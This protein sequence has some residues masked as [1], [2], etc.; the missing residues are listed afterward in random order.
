MNKKQIL[1]IGLI[2]GLIAIYVAFNFYQKIYGESV[3][4]Q[5]FI[6]IK[7]GDSLNELS[8]YLKP[9]IKDIEDFKWVAKQKSYTKIRAGKFEIKKGI[10]NNDLINHLR[11]GKQTPV[12]VVFNNQDTI[13]KLAGRIA[14][15]IEAD[16]LEILT[17]ITDKKFLSKI[18][19]SREEILGRFIPNTYEFFWNTS[20]VDFRGR[21]LKEYY[22]FWNENRLAKAKKLNMTPIEVMNLASI[23]QK[24]TNKVVERPIVAGLYLNRLKSKMPLQADPT[25][26]YILKQQKGQD[27]IVKRV[28][29]KD[30]KIKSP[31]NTYQNRGLP[32]AL[33]SM[34]DI[35]SIDA[36][37]N[38]KKHNFYYMCA[39]VDN[40]GYH[41][42]ANSLK[43]HNRNAKRYQRQLNLQG[44]LR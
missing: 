20:G 11:V 41:E 33:I 31:Y 16:S 42:F 23:V 3:I 40:P 19:A 17:A 4:K 34:P 30:L 26:V 27:F 22:R 37:L 35:S 9:Y 14:P 7:T 25:I 8:T 29:R 32:P 6:F 38:Y 2:T 44:I 39:S 18:G 24:E 15:Q 21:M 28:L 5:G 13:E 36:V 10:S 43:Q 1:G 12:K